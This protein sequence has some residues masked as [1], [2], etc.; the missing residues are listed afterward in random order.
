MKQIISTNRIVAVLIFC[1]CVSSLSVASV[2]KKKYGGIK[3][4][5]GYQIQQSLAVDASAWSIHG[6]NGMTIEFESGF[7]EGAAAN[8]EHRELYSWYREQSI[9]GHRVALALVKPGVKTVFEPKDS[10]GTGNILLVTFRLD[11]SHPSY[12]ANFQVKVLNQD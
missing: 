5:P 9:N 6:V 12:T 1:L 2:N 4:L 10:R 8:P 3:L 7:S 11:P